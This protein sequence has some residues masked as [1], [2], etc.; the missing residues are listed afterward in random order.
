M[1][2]SLRGWPPF[3]SH[4]AC[5][6]L[7]A[8]LAHLAQRPPE[9]GLRLPARS[10]AL[11]LPASALRGGATQARR[12]GK[13]ALLHVRPGGELCRVLREPVVLLARHPDTIVG[14][15]L[16]R[17]GELARA[18]KFGALVISDGAA[19]VPACREGPKVTYGGG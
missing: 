13:V 12:G 8:S 1:S 15:E 5:L 6:V 16:K 14:M 17:L 19:A 11:S 7:G 10:V 4:A 3:A 9:P 2:L 18:G